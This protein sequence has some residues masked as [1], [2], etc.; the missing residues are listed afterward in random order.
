MEAA[1]RG[2]AEAGG[3]TFGLFPGDERSPANA[4][5]TV[6]VPT[7]MGELRNALV[8]RS[9]DAVVAAGDGLGTLSEVALALKPGRPVIGVGSGDMTAWVESIDD[10]QAAARRVLELVTKP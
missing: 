8:V 2:A 4:W 1:C 9:A 6:T 3:T 7:G 5:V 10:A